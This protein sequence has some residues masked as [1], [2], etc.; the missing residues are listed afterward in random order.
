MSRNYEAL[1]RRLVVADFSP[2]LPM[3]FCP[4]KRSIKSCMAVKPSVNEYSALRKKKYSALTA[5]R[6]GV[7]SPDCLHRDKEY[8]LHNMQPL[9]VM[10]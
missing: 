6:K 1:E 2:T 8:A 9:T 4:E 3:T 5:L 7:F 10:P